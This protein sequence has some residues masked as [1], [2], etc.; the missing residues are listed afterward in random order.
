MIAAGFFKNKRVT[1]IILHGL[2][3]A[4]LLS[5]PYLFN[6]N[7]VPRLMVVVK[8]SW[9]PIGFSA[10]IFY[11]NYFLLVD[12]LLFRKKMWLF[13]GSNAVLVMAIYW[14]NIY[15]KDL[16][17]P[18]N[19]VSLMDVASL[20]RLAR[21]RELAR[22]SSVV[23]FVL[24]VVLCVA[25]KMTGRWMKIEAEKDK[26]EKM[27][28]EAELIHLRYQ[29]QPHFFFNSLNNIYAL[30]D[31]SPDVAK[32]A[33]HGLA[34]LMRYL[35]YET[36]NEKMS[37]ATEI[38]FLIKYIQLMELRLTKNIMV[39]YDFPEDGANYQVAPLLFIP[40]LENAFKHGISPSG[41]AALFFKMEVN[42]HQLVFTTG[43]PNVP[44]DNTDQSG[45]GIG[46][47]NLRKRLDLIYPDHYRFS[48]EVANNRYTTTLVINFTDL[49]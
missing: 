23:S 33:V 25:L 16:F 32:N 12:R 29:L 46:L 2:I 36:N 28:L 34:K 26:S 45:S 7:G 42:K 43:N 31:K 13:I 19:N 37:L 18:T 27:R 1:N 24:S 10:I 39:E 9:L 35:L 41:N 6:A 17:P 44:V 40:L 49:P 47:D 38:D 15:V 30:I 3:W 8:R 22:Y 4:A 21:I 14:L 20:N 48:S 11:L 5:I